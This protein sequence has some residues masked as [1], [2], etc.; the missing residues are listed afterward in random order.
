MR[1]LL[2]VLTRGLLLLGAVLLPSA[3]PPPSGVPRADLVLVV[4]AAVALVRGPT[5]GLLAGLAGGWMLDLV[6][7]GGSP[8][9]AGAL[10]HAAAGAALGLA[11]PLVRV[12]PVLP[13]LLTAGAAALVLGVRGVASAAGAGLA[14]PGDLGWSWVV[15]AAVAAVLL[16]LLLLLERRV[17]GDD[18]TRPTAPRGGGVRPGDLPPARS[19]W[20]R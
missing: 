14:R 11:R 2:A 19:G 18:P 6:P 4:V 5:A 3:L 15:T 9:G 10:V 17:G 12:S 8:L 1:G 7:P 13:W 16:P 20:S